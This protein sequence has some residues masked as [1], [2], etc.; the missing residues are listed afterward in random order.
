MLHNLHI[1]FISLAQGYACVFNLQAN[2]CIIN[3]F[4]KTNQKLHTAVNDPVKKEPQML[5]FR[6][7]A[8]WQAW[9]DKNYALPEGI[10]LKIAK[11]DTGVTTV[12]YQEAL[13]VA[14]CY[15][16]IDGLVN[17]LDDK[18]YIQKFTPR[19]PRSIWSKRNVGIVNELIAEGKM[20]LPGYKAIEEAKAD[21]RW[22]AAY[23]S[24]GNMTVPE[25]FIDELKKHSQAYNFFQ[26]LNKTNLFAIGFRLQTAKKPETRN[27]RMK[28]IIEMLSR[29]EKFH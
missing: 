20:Q 8:D 4:K 13:R 16:W 12:N 17:K 23:D 27:K 10:W 28:E 19:R 6:T 5:E 9:L 7:E 3:G 2:T 15:G 18:Y 21:G 25:Y 24:P 26:S 11:K 29:N 1:F 14:L 22:D